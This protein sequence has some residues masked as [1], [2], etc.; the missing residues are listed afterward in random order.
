[1]NLNRTVKRRIVIGCLVLFCLLF[2]MI[3]YWTPLAG[4]DWGYAL[5]GMRNNPFV[6]CF[7][8]YFNWSG[9]ILSELWGYIVAPRKWLWNILNP[10]LFTGIFMTILAI[11]RP[12]KNLIT[13]TLVIM[14]LI[15]SVKDY[16]RMQTYTWIMGTTYVIPLLLL[17]IYTLILRKL[18]IDNDTNK[19]M[20]YGCYL[21]NLAVPLY[22]ENAGAAIMV[23]NILCIIFA[24][25][26]DKKKIKQLSI[27]LLIS[28]IG[29]MICRMSPGAVYRL[30]NEHAAWLS[31][32]IFEQIATNWNNFL[33]FTFLDN[34]Y[35]ICVLSIVLFSYTIINR[36]HYSHSMI[37]VV[38][39]AMVYLFGIIQSI[40]A[41]INSILHIDALQI[42][43]NIEYP[44]CSL[45]ISILLILYILCVIITICNFMDYDRRY[46]SLYVLM[47]GGSANIAM[48][49][50]P[51][52]DSRS[53]IYNIFFLILLTVIF[54]DDMNM[55][56]YVN[57]GILAIL[58]LMNLLQFKTYIYKYHLVNEVQKER[59][60]QIYYY[61]DHPEDTNGYFVRMPIMTI[62]SAD[63]EQ[64][65]TFHQEV[66]K[67][68]YGL[69]PEIELHFY[70]KEHY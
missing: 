56:Y 53:S 68:Y 67:E 42:L 52:F 66:F 46:L 44:G 62:H 54:L 47:V 14:F 5:T 3:T 58:I 21:I 31:M 43:Y 60:E 10:A 27:F 64:W 40:S 25:F 70:F 51:I 9:R 17:L 22:M 13:C 20:I 49:L 24:F 61:Q 63:I 15:L 7:R 18:L 69:N 4:D 50:S 26:D 39:I 30:N 32:S 37:H 11:A 36:Y 55:N 19:Y 23:A 12:R 48:L 8:Q 41:N 35:L 59:M 1:M 34:K 28:I 65:D 45:V 57:L 2:V 16:V 29:F 6:A 38:L 33:R